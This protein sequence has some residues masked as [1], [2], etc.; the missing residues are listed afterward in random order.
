MT[1]PLPSFS[2]RATPATLTGTSNAEDGTALTT[3]T[4]SSQAIGSADSGRYVI[5]G[6][7]A[8]NATANRSIS[9]ATI[10]G[11]SATI[12][13]EEHATSGGGYFDTGIIIANVPTGTTADVV[14]VWSAGQSAC[15]IGTAAAYNLQSGTATA[16]DSDTSVPGSITVTVQDGGIAFGSFCGLSGSVSWTGFT[17]YSD[18]LIIGNVVSS[19]A[20]YSGQVQEG[21]VT[22]TTTPGG[23]PTEDAL[24]GA[25]FR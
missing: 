9:S 8:Y 12:V 4:F 2:P 13:V 3:Y 11:I 1:F 21:D 23:A 25:S 16:T 20:T 22:A 6:V 10:G 7:N 5:V 17:E 15:G 19:V 18:N 14:V 24:V